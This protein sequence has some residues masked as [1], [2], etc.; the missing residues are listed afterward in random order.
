MKKK[1]ATAGSFKVGQPR[2][3]NAGRKKGT[4]NKRTVELQ[5][6]LAELD[7]DPVGTLSKILKEQMAIF[8]H[9]KKNRQLTGALIALSDAE[10][11]TSNL[12]QYLY[13]KKKAIEHTGDVG[14]RTWADFIAAASPKTNKE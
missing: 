12:F 14:V 3:A 6:R 4:P 10:R 9:R 11:T 7:V 5:E 8:E 13:P 1:P 2:P